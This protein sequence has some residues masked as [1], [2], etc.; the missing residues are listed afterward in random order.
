MCPRGGTIDYAIVVGEK[1]GF[2]YNLKGQQEQA[3][4]NDS[5]EPSER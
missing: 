1:E 2:I 4:V 5:M 3:W